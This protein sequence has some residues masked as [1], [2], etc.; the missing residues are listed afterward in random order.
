GGGGAERGPGD[1]HLPGGGVTRAGPADA[2]PGTLRVAAIY[3]RANGLGDV[4]LPHALALAHATAALDSAVFVR[5][6]RELGAIARATPTV[7]VQTRRQYLDAVKAQGR[8]NAESQW[9]VDALMILIA[10]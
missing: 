3:S 9:V 1:A 2:T 4:V 6:G 10:A 7:V 5:G 8:Q